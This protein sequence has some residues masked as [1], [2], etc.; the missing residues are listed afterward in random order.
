MREKTARLLARNL[1]H[2]GL[3]THAKL[4]MMIVGF[5]CAVGCSGK[6]EADGIGG[7]GNDFVPVGADGCPLAIF[8]AA[9]ARCIPPK[10]PNQTCGAA[11]RC[12]GVNNPNFIVSGSLTTCF[13]G[14][15]VRDGTEGVCNCGAPELAETAE[16]T[17]GDGGSGGEGGQPLG[18][19]GGQG[20]EA[21]GGA[22]GAPE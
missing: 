8:Q 12:L 14:T 11:P 16:C 17:G 22:G 15:W 3:M 19:A 4:G 13:Q 2:L 10:T 9:G 1:L 21:I 5:W 18:G 20:G 7:S 6:S